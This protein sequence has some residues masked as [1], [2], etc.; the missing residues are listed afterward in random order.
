MRK[1]LLNME[2]NVLVYQAWLLNSSEPKGEVV[3]HI[4]QTPY[5]TPGTFRMQKLASLI[6][7]DVFFRTRRDNMYPNS[8]KVSPKAVQQTVK[9]WRFCEQSMHA[10]P[11][12]RCEAAVLE[13]LLS[14]L[15][16]TPYS[17]YPLFLG[18]MVTLY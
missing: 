1:G 6:F 5:L 14:S 11:M 16:A 15:N 2:D 13:A 10:L 17:K 7:M 9:V 18:M 3:Q 8:V 4:F 12:G